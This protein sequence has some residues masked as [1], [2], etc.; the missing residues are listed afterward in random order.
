[1]L[2]LAVHYPHLR[3]RIQPEQ[4]IQVGQTRFRVPDVCIL[5]GHAPRQKVIDIAPEL[6]IEILSPQ[7]TL[8][9]TMERV[10][11]Y[12]NM[13]VPLCWIVDPVGRA[14]WVATSGRLEEAT[15]GVLRAPG[16]EMPLAEVLE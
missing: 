9:R 15:D 7:D 2:F 4:R 6:C 14:G 10:R 1:M 3:K 12:F 16:I 5:A 8:P 13:G 11:D